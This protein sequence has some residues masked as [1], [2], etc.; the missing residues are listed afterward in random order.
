MVAA[1][2]ADCRRAAMAKLD[3]LKDWSKDP[4]SFLIHEYI[5]SALV[6]GL[7]SIHEVMCTNPS[8]P[9]FLPVFIFFP[10]CWAMPRTPSFGPYIVF[11]CLQNLPIIQS[12]PVLQKA[13]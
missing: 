8:L 5:A 7:I 2:D 13:P 4:G 1:V 6:S 11:P 3:L 12:L 10:C 9:K